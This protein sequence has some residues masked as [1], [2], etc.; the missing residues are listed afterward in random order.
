MAGEVRV[1]EG[2]TAEARVMLFLFPTIFLVMIATHFVSGPGA[3]VLLLVLIASVVY[4]VLRSGRFW[5]TSERLVWKPLVGEPVQIPLRSIPEDG[6]RSFLLSV[7]VEG[8]RKRKRSADH[9]FREKGGPCSVASQE[10]WTWDA[11]RQRWKQ[12]WRGQRR[13]ATG[14][15]PKRGRYS[16]RMRR[17][18]CRWRSS[19]AGMGLGRSG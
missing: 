7:R 11:T 16:R 19:P 1:L 9:T 15:S 4:T 14:R 13:A 8:E 10:V 12:H 6:I 18:G 17:A 3:F 5:L 2:D